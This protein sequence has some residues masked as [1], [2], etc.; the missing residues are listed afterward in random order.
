MTFFTTFLVSLF[1]FLGSLSNPCLNFL[2]IKCFLVRLAEEFSCREMDISGQK[3][4]ISL[5]TLLLRESYV[6]LTIRLSS[7]VEK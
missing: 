3:V 2:A 4:S 1:L 6:T 5:M 7:M